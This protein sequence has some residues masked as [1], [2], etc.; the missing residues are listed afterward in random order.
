MPEGT[1]M[2]N[3]VHIGNL[4]LRE[5][6]AQRRSASWLAEQLS[7]DR[8]NVYKIFKKKDLD[9]QLLLRISRILG[10]DFFSIYTTLLHE[11]G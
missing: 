7:C 11:R 9:T 10:R 6:T 3:E 5:L 2:K 4:I 8:T 1:R